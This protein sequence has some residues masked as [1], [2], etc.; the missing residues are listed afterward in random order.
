MDILKTENKKELLGGDTRKKYLFVC[1]GNT[2]RSP[3]AEAVF[4]RL[5]KNEDKVATSAGMS[6]GGAPL[7]Q[8]AKTALES[9]GICGF[10]HISSM[11]SFEDMASAECVIGMTY[12]HAQRLMMCFPEFASKIVALPIDIEDPYGG[13]IDV[14]KLCLGQ[15][16]EALEMAFSDN[17]D[18]EDN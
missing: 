4:N 13:D 2:C 7:S 14:Y 16:C 8:N 6:P 3:M 9:I 12:Q 11:V 18:N 1:T 10:N 17:Y 15:I 5:Y